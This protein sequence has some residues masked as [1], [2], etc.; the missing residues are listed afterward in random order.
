MVWHVI[1]K[2]LFY[3]RLTEV[4][5]YTHWNLQHFILHVAIENIKFLFVKWVDTSDQS[6]IKIYDID[7]TCIMLEKKVARGKAT[8]FVG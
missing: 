8:E 5:T 4:I 7:E 6:M 2:T 1:V 3:K